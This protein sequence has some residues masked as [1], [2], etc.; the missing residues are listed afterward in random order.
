MNRRGVLY[1]LGGLAVAAG[2]GAFAWTSATGSMAD[3]EA[4]QTRLRAVPAGPP[5]IP[6]ILRYAGMAANGHNTQPWRFALSGAEAGIA[7][8]LSRRTPVV[9]PDDHHLYVSLGCA[10]E[11]LAIAARAGGLRTEE[12]GADEN[13]V[14]FAVTATAPQSTPLYDAIPRR[15]STRAPYDGRPLAADTLKALEAAA[16]EPGV[17]LILVTERARID[18]VRDLVLE[19]NGAQMTDPA[20]IAEL[21]AWLRFNPDA[22]MKTGDGLFAAASGNPVMPGPVAR[23]A[24]DAFFK[25]GSENAK[26]AAH[27][28]STPALAVFFG[29]AARPANWIRVGRACQRLALTATSLGLKHCFVN[30]PVEVAALR[31]KLAALLGEGDLRPD[32]VIRL[33]YGEAL[34]YSPRRPVETTMAG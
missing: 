25:P 8:D 18:A 1:G 10:A 26:Y 7:P 23:L 31:P 16:A 32:L 6:D 4:W 11:N 34:P 9:D 29:E 27:M 12:T 15:Q 19:G 17:R 3:Y 28:A 33:G 21:K 13:G 14:R 20:F 22:A 5:S 30:Q 2:A 24:F